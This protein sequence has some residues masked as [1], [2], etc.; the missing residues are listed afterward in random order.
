MWGGIGDKPFDNTS[1][2]QLERQRRAAIVR[3]IELFPA[4]GQCASVV[5]LDG[6]AVCGLAVALDGLCDVDLEL[7]GGCEGR[8]QEEIGE[9]GWEMH[10]V[11]GR[12]VRI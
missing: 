6:V 9:E 7:G 5:H 3:S 1:S 4:V 10:F 12:A 8:G 2:T 11:F